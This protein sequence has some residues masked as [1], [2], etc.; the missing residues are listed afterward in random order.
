[1]LDCCSVGIPGRG[2]GMG[3]LWVGGGVCPQSVLLYYSDDFQFLKKKKSFYE[4]S[5]KSVLDGSP[6]GREG[7]RSPG[8]YRI[9]LRRKYGG[10]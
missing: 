3:G 1:M 7:A 5:I 2:V 9:F 4:S 10:F 6:E 8:H